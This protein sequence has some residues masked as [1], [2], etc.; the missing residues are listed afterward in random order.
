MRKSFFLISLFFVGSIFSS[1]AAEI[2]LVCDGHMV[3]TTIDRRGSSSDEHGKLR[4]IFTMDLD[5]M[6]VTDRIE[7]DFV[8]NCDLRLKG[9]FN[10]NFFCSKI[11]SEKEDDNCKATE[12]LYI[13][14][15]ERN[16]SNVRLLKK[17]RCL[18]PKGFVDKELSMIFN[19][20]CRSE[21]LKKLF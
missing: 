18:D 12:R 5:T 1:N 13:L 9:E 2:P 21:K 14:R 10:E 20:I 16:S 6:T 19:G 4:Q 7:N 3:V 8:I 11:I 15:I 17:N